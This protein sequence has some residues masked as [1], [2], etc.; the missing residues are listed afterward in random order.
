MAK[1]IAIHALHLASLVPGVTDVINPGEQFDTIETDGVDRLKSLGAVRKAAEAD[2]GAPKAVRAAAKVPAE[3]AVEDESALGKMTKAELLAVAEA[4]GIEVDA[5]A[6]K[7]VLIKA[8]E[9]A[10]AAANDSLV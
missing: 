2:S 3:G 7:A 5:N 9:D 4:E 8:I 10:R 6:N 1:L